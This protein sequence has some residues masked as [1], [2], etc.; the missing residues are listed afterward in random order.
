MES[1]TIRRVNRASSG[2]SMIE[3][4]IVMTVMVA[5]LALAVPSFKSSQRVSRANGMIREVATQMRLVR[6]E[7]MAQLRAETLQYDDQNKQIVVIRHTTSGVAVLTNG[8][9]PNNGTVVR[10]ISLNIDGLTGSD[11]IYGRPSGA[12]TAALSDNTNL[13]ALTNSKINI[14]FQPD[15]SVINAAGTPVD[16]ALFIYNQRSSTETAAAISVLGAAGRV[17]TWRYSSSANKYLE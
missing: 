8:G 2:F 14:T 7:S 3:L 6:Q 1:K 11:I 15:G 16:I 4:I 13:T 5:I 10:T 9:Y 17:K 12:S